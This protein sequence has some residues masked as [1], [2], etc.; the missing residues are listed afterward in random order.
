MSE[1]GNHWYCRA[2]L[3]DIT[4]GESEWLLQVDQ[5]QLRLIARSL[6][7]CLL[8][9]NPPGLFR[10]LQKL[11]FRAILSIISQ[12]QGRL[13]RQDA[14]YCHSQRLK[15]DFI[16]LFNHHVSLASASDWCD[17]S[18]GTGT[19]VLGPVLNIWEGAGEFKL[20]ICINKPFLC[21]TSPLNSTLQRG[22]RAVAVLVWSGLTFHST[23]YILLS[24]QHGTSSPVHLSRSQ[25][26]GGAATRTV[27]SSS[28]KI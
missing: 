25:A 11:F 17:P 21:N 24:I 2:L 16:L 18:P 4:E 19:V 27:T 14:F 23:Y 7:P 28:V 26:Q 5:P 15:G 8:A 1:L 9:Q 6:L 22:D 10:I 3:E 20:V 13:D 12:T